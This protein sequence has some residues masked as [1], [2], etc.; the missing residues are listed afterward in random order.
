MDTPLKII[1]FFRWDFCCIKLCSERNPSL[2]FAEKA[3]KPPCPPRSGGL[4]L[5][6][7]EELLGVAY[8]LKLIF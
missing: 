1:T 7:W 2:F 4:P 3:Q 5:E 6:K 8:F